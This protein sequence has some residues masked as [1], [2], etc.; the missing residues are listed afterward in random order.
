MRLKTRLVVVLGLLVAGYTGLRTVS[1][2]RSIARR[3]GR[4]LRH[5]ADLQTWEGEGGNVVT[6]SRAIDN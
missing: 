1:G 3:Q 5:K 2:P 6:P 4:K